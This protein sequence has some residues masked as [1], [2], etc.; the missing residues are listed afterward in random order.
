[1]IVFAWAP[2]HMG[3]RGNSAAD[4]A[5]K[6]AIDGDISDELVSISD[7]KPQLNK[8][9]LELWSSVRGEC[10]NNKLH[11]LALSKVE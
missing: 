1:M 2:G 7:L 9:Q 3:F 10:P 6:N 4:S 5:A 11:N 8:Y